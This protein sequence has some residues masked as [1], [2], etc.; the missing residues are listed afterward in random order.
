VQR[1][2]CYDPAGRLTHFIVQ[3]PSG[4]QASTMVYDEAGHLTAY[5][6]P[7]GSYSYS[8]SYNTNG[9]RRSAVVNGVT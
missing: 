8:Y 4:V 9:N 6:G 5:S 1:S 3:T 7:A 2:Y